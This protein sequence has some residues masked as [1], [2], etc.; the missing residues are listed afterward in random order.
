M[1][2]AEQSERLT[3]LVNKIDVFV[4]GAEDRTISTNAGSL[5]SL[6]GLSKQISTIQWVAKV[7]DFNTLADLYLNADDLEVGQV[8]R[9]LLDVTLSNRGYYQKEAL[10]IYKISYA[11]LFDL[12]DRFP[13][14]YNKI[15]LDLDESD[16]Q[17]STKN[18]FTVRIPASAFLD[19]W[20]ATGRLEY[21]SNVTGAGFFYSASFSLA[22]SARQATVTDSAYTKALESV[23]GGAAPSTLPALQAV[24]AQ[25]AGDAMFTVRLAVAKQGTTII[26]GKVKIVLENMST[27]PIT[28]L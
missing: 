25:D 2:I 1:S 7:I 4:N 20:S 27:D 26:P 18:L 19:G 13:D 10:G 21:T 24:A 16:T 28:I 8:A 23:L 17:G 14:P 6:A 3:G 22:L 12:H 15:V 9:V 5:K 11:D